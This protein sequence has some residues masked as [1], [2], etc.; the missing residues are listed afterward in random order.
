[1]RPRLHT[2]RRDGAK[3]GAKMNP[4]PTEQALTLAQV[5]RSTG[6][7]RNTIPRWQRQ[8][9]LPLP[10]DGIY[11]QAY[12]D[13]ILRTFPMRKNP[14]RKRLAQKELEE[15]REKSRKELEERPGTRKPSDPHPC[16]DSS[17][18]KEIT[19]IR[20]LICGELRESLADTDYQSPPHLSQRYSGCP[21]LSLGRQGLPR[22]L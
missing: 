12:V 1:M 14:P 2:R 15:L 21:R 18:G 10:S 7:D 4:Q 6:R 17:G 16:D 13:L 8:G 19:G 22:L 3:R 11:T 5:A 9:K 20:C